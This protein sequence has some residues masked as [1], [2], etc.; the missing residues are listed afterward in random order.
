M[1]LTEHHSCGA[2]EYTH[3][4]TDHGTS[5]IEIVTVRHITHELRGYGL[6][7]ENSLLEDGVL[8]LHD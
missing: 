8:S 3:M 5:L 6:K 2:R 1:D 7:L 4:V